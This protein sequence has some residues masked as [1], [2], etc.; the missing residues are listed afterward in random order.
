[1]K[2]MSNELGQ[3]SLD[4]GK[5]DKMKYEILTLEQKNLNTGEKTNDAMV[6][7]VRKVIVSIADQTY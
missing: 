2:A 5:L 4:Q 3:G 7:L 1:M 6:D